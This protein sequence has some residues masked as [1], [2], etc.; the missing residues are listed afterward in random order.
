M[1]LISTGL[2]LNVVLADSGGNKSTQR[3]QLDSNCA[4]YA[5]LEAA[6]SAAG[7]TRIAEVLGNIALVSNARIVGYS[8]GEG[9]KEDTNAYGPI[10]SEVERLANVVG[11]VDGVIGKYHTVRIPSPVAGLFVNDGAPGPKK[12]DID[13]AD[14]DLLSFMAHF[15]ATISDVTPFT[16]D[17]L[18][19]DG[20]KLEDVTAANISGKQIHRG[21]RKG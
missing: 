6:G 19:S 9:F 1:A 4:A 18:V 5:T 2:F 13:P 3:Y 15:Q 12:N 21:S 8:V 11:Q 16:G 10:D 17:F 20:E 7:Q 14:A